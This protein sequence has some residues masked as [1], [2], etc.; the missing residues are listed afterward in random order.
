MVQ[1]LPRGPNP[2]A[3]MD[4]LLAVGWRKLTPAERQARCQANK[5]Q[6]QQHQAEQAESAV[7]D[8][9]HVTEPQH[10]EPALPLASGAPITLAHELPVTRIA[11]V[12]PCLPPWLASRKRTASDAPLGPPLGP[13]DVATPSR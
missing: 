1:D 9:A 7:L 10:H 4:K 3:A 11:L 13:D 12:V 2:I 8:C 6:K 5:R